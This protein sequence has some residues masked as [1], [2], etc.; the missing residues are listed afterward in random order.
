MCPGA[1]ALGA[2][3]EALD[4]LTLVPTR[5]FSPDKERSGQRWALQMGLFHLPGV[6][7]VLPGMERPQQLL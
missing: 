1:M 4:H 7:E 6:N 3:T 5:A 2:S